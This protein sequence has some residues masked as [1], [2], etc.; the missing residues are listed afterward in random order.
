MRQKK[1]GNVFSLD[2]K[3]VKVTTENSFGSEFH[4]AGAEH[5]KARSVLSIVFYYL[6]FHNKQHYANSNNYHLIDIHNAD[7]TNIL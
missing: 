6:T 5:R 1:N 7:A 4:T 3:T 2:L